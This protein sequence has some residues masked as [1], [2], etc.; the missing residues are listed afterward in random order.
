MSIAEQMPQDGME[1]AHYSERALPIPVPEAPPEP[2]DDGA[3]NQ[4]QSCLSKMSAQACALEAVASELA[5]LSADEN[6]LE[7]VAQARAMAS[8][9]RDKVSKISLEMG[10]SMGR[11]GKR[12]SPARAAALVGNLN[13]MLAVAEHEKHEL[14]SAIH[15]AAALPENKEKS[16]FARMLAKAT[17]PVVVTA[18]ATVAVGATHG[19]ATA[20]A[21]HALR[22]LAAAL[23]PPPMSAWKEN[24]RHATHEVM[25]L[26]TQSPRVQAMA[27]FSR[28]MA[29]GAGDLVIST[30]GYMKDHAVSLGRSTA[31]IASDYVI[32]PVAKNIVD[33]VVDAGKMA[34]VTTKEAA[35]YIKERATTTAQ[36]VVRITKEVGNNI[37]NARDE[38]VSNIMAIPQQVNAVA[39]QAVNKAGQWMSEK[40]EWAVGLWRS[41]DVPS[42]AATAVDK[43]E[44]KPQ[45]V[46][47]MAAKA[48]NDN[49]PACIANRTV[50]ASTSFI[51]EQ[52][53]KALKQA[54]SLKQAVAA[55]S[56]PLLP[57]LSVADL[58][59]SSTPKLPQIQAV[60]GRLSGAR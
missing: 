19:V 56:L 13:Q 46:A 29:A 28:Q 16:T 45:A 4:L 18:K 37:A 10:A 40:K 47:S 22:Q 15:E 44:A 20:S 48:A 57:V 9:M 60:F 27:N 26:I 33:P 49:L 38:A 11:A 39:K 36:S 24:L 52:M 21:P 1:N 2:V 51:D 54:Q 31:Q 6:A 53:Q 32:T 14:V 23:A 17:A 42:K 5:E 25:Q 7:M 34:W 43:T 3:A 41:N 50:P 55:F 12:V 8:E 59:P 35:V 58:V 30:V